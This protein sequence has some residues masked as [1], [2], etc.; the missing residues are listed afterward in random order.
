MESEIKKEPVE[1]AEMSEN[2][3][4]TQNDRDGQD[5]TDVPEM[6]DEEVLAAAEA[7][8]FCMGDAVEL[9]RLAK[10]VGRS[11]PDMKKLMEQLR[12]A[13]LQQRRGIRLLELD[14]SYQL[15]S[16]RECYPSIIRIA[17]IP[18]KIRLTDV[19]ME[20]LSII[21]YKQPVTKGEIEQIRGVGSDHAVNKLIEFG[22]VE[23]VGRLEAP[24]RPILFGTTEEF[25]RHFGIGS[26]EMLPEIDPLQREDFKAEAEEE[27]DTKLKV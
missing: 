26:L 20:T 16:A 21:A 4:D 10:A 18:K 24:G 13:Y 3:Q 5:H 6:T 11:S 22:L 12:L 8:L 15:C 25:L 17:K 19:L 2:I 27:V 7:I 23:E 1:M 14:G 9:E